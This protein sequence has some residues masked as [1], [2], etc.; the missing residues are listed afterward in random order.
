MLFSRLPP[1]RPPPPALP[2]SLCHPSSSG[3]DDSILQT[4]RST[5]M[6]RSFLPSISTFPL[7]ESP[8]SDDDDCVPPT[9]TCPKTS[10]RAVPQFPVSNDRRTGAAMGEIGAMPLSSSPSEPPPPP[11]LPRE[12]RRLRRPPTCER[13]DQ[14]TSMTDSSGLGTPIQSA[15]RI[16]PDAAS[17]GRKRCVKSLRE[18]APLR[19]S[20]ESGRRRE[21]T[22]SAP[23][24][25]AAVDARAHSGR[26][27]A[28]ASRFFLPLW[29]ASF[30]FPSSIRSRNSSLVRSAWIHFSP[31]YLTAST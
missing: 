10:L 12:D 28:V 26:S 4:S 15:A 18:S 30:R 24:Y 3:P 31:Q 6:A 7:L 9:S 25:V 14:S 27:S 5:S 11:P 17:P 22:R 29:P 2:S 8:R 1:R 23:G 13:L 20:G 16:H 19:L 21:D